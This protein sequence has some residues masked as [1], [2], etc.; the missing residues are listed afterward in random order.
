MPKPY[1]AARDLS[2]KYAIMG[3]LYIRPMHGYDLHKHLQLNLHEVWHISQSQAYNIIKNLQKAGCLTTILQPQDKRPDREM[4]QLTERGKIDFE[5][6]LYTPT[7]GSARAIRVEF[8]T[9]LFFATNLSEHLSSRLIQEQITAINDDLNILIK[10]VSAIPEQQI[11]NRMGLDLRIRQLTGVVAWL[12]DCHQ[13][14]AE[15]VV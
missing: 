10:R 9:R 12:E 13:F 2:P 14:F 7:S 11:F 15:G 5:A 4:L 6:W 1:S 3:F 8:I